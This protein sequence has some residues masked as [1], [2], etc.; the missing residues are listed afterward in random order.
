MTRRNQIRLLLLVVILLV[1]GQA[2]TFDFVDWDDGQHIFKNENIVQH[3]W[4]GL[5]HHWDPMN[6]GNPQMYC[7][8]VFTVWWL[9]A[10]LSNVQSPDIFGATLNPYIF[11]AANL[12]VHWLCA[13]AVLEILLRLKIRAWAAGA[14]TLIFAVHP[15][16]VEAVAWASGMKDLLSGFFALLAIWRYIAAL[17]SS[18]R[19]RKWN[20]ALS[21]I[22]YVGALLS[23]PSTVVTPLIVGAIELII[24]RRPWKS[25]L[26]WTWPWYALGI[27]ATL[28]TIKIQ[29]L[30]GWVGGPLWA[31]PLIALD[32]LAFYL[33]KLILPIGLKFD[34]GRNPQAVLTDPSLHHPLYWTWIFPV[35]VAIAIWRSRRKELIL[36]GSIFF[37]ALLPELGLKTFAYQYYSTV[38]DRY[39]YLSMLGVALAVAW[40]L[41]RHGTRPMAVVVA[42]VIGVLGCLSFVQAQQWTD[43][44]TLYSNGLDHTR[45]SHLIALGSYQDD[46]AIPY[47]RRAEQANQMGHYEEGRELADQALAYIDK[48]MEYYRTVM[49]LDPTN[50]HAYD[51]LA[52]DLVRLNRIPEAID[53]VKAWIQYDGR[54]TLYT[55]EQPGRLQA[56]LGTLYL[57]NRQY[58][59]AIEALKRSLAEKNN[60]DVRQTLEMAQKL[61]AT[62]KSE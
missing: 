59:E 52:T 20:Y 13:C 28:I 4:A 46:L 55:P 26:A 50:T 12:V 30:E 42:C 53:V 6:T 38:A 7:P 17:E 16:Q 31:H 34:F 24:Y 54:S 21:T 32:S 27:A 33:G 60:P 56:M 35:A 1:F 45:P 19:G 39:V 36:A 47:M 58:P 61:A 8:M 9:L 29:R 43:T 37:L 22:F 14:G 40:W 2:M 18:G 44:E 10:H 49:R 3:T 15:L 51:L 57:K 11:H 23:K 48:A 41:D 62:R 5:G 25:V